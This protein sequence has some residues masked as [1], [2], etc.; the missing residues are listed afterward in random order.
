VA[1]ELCAAGLGHGEG[2][3]RFDDG[4][5]GLVGAGIVGR[6]RGGGGAGVALERVL[7][8]EKV[9]GQER[10]RL[11]GDDRVRGAERVLERAHAVRE[12]GDLGV[13]VLGRREHEPVALAGG[14]GPC[15]A[16]I[17][18]RP[19][20]AVEPAR[21]APSGQMALQPRLTQDEPVGTSRSV[22]Q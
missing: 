12:L 7:D 9:L 17:V 11:C 3:D 22:G 18:R 6:G 14:Q 8:P 15:G 10:V 19:A 4:A 13:Q 16:P 1:E 21:S 5:F 2:A 20:P